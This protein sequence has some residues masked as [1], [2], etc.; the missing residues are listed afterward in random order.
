ML[1]ESSTLPETG[2]TD[3]PAMYRAWL[4]EQVGDERDPIRLLTMSIRLSGRLSGS[5]PDLARV[6]THHV[7]ASSTGTEGLAPGVV[8]HLVAAVSSSPF[9]ADDPDVAVVSAAG[10]ITAVLRVTVEREPAEQVRIIDAAARNV[11]RMFG[12]DEKLIAELLALPLPGV[13]PRAG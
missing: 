5:H 11:L 2:T 9:S 7:A 6:L 12:T 8:E 10:A 13:T 4:D 3:S 1:S